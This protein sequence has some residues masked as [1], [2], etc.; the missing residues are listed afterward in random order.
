MYHIV[1]V[2]RLSSKLTYKSLSEFRTSV[3]RHRTNAASGT[4]YKTVTSEVQFIIVI[5]S[6][7]KIY[8]LPI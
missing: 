1:T 7:L 3:I 4:L 8:F 5:N 2:S 6:A